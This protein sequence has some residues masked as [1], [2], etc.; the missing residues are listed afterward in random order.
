MRGT[1][2]S[3]SAVDAGIARPD[4]VEPL[5]LP[6]LPEAI[7]F[8]DLCAVVLTGIVVLEGTARAARSCDDVGGKLTLSL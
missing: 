1:Y 6:K 5:G 8:H 7:L 4:T 3:P 2:D